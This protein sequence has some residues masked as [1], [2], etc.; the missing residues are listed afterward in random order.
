[1]GYMDLMGWRK[2]ISYIN[3]YMVHV[4]CVFVYMAGGDA[5]LAFLPRNC[6][7]IN[8]LSTKIRWSTE[9]ASAAKKRKV[10]LA[11]PIL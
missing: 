7:M 8:G 9:R 5:D 1:M 10:N 4:W 6:N 11:C 2:Q 3:N